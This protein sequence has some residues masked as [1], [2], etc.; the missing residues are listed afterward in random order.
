MTSAPPP[1]SGAPGGPPNPPQS[2]QP[3]PP[4]GPNFAQYP[5]SRRPGPG[6][7]PGFAEGPPGYSQPTPPHGYPP[8]QPPPHAYQPYPSQPYQAPPPGHGPAGQPPQGFGPY[9]PPPTYGPPR[10]SGNR[11]A[12]IVAGVL[13]VVLLVPVGLL[14]SG[15]WTPGG[16]ASSTPGTEPT[17][18]QSPGQTTGPQQSD[19]Q[20]NGAMPIGSAEA[21]FASNAYAEGATPVKIPTGRV[22]G[23]S[24][25]GKTVAAWNMEGDS[26]TYRGWGSVKN[27]IVLVDVATAKVRDTFTTEHCS[28]GFVGNQL[29]CTGGR[30][31]SELGFFPK[32]EHILFAHDVNTGSQSF[33]IPLPETPIMTIVT[34]GEVGGTTLIALRYDPGITEPK[35]GEVIAVKADGGV[36]W[37]AETG[38]VE[39]QLRG[40]NV[41]CMPE[42]GAPEGS[43][44]AF[45]SATGKPTGTLDLSRFLKDNQN[46]LAISAEGHLVVTTVGGPIDINA[47]SEADSQAFDLSGKEVGDPFEAVALEPSS[48]T[49]GGIG[50]PLNAL[51]GIRDYA[52]RAYAADGANTAMGE[53]GSGMDEKHWTHFATGKRTKVLGTTVGVTLDGQILVTTVKGD[54]DQ[55]LVQLTNLATGEQVA[56][57]PTTSYFGLRITHGV[58]V[59]DSYTK[60]EMVVLVPA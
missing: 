14:L 19:K 36:A 50:Y 8:Q 13:A 55:G 48:I 16:T 4:V 27:N 2:W 34:L 44:V 33:K 17:P 40:D 10:R 52:A 46:R 18:G 22:L 5:V 49:Y 54:G 47:Q 24:G 38:D 51:V 59:D 45:A 60:G 21:N 1:P 43:L 20:V 7:R 39:C 23:I 53:Y 42:S 41:M 25:D 58:I 31:D 26:D 15:V 28:E 12:W 35:S 11:V 3:G 30:K 57:A 37:R 6:P 29:F 56:S 32:G 9:G